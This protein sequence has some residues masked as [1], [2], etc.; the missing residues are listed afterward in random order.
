[1]IK[2]ERVK[3]THNTVDDAIGNAEALLIL[4]KEYGLKMKF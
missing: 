4:K 2:T 3:H 1:M